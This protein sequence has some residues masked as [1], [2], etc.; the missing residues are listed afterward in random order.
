M[1]GGTTR[2]EAIRRHPTVIGA[3]I[4]PIPIIQARASLAGAFSKLKPS[5]LRKQE[6]RVP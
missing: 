3:D 6:S 4:N 1:G 2:H 5:F